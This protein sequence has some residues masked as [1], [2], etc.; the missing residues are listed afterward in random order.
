MSRSYLLGL[1][2]LA[3]AACAGV[4]G[5][6]VFKPTRY[7]HAVEVELAP[8]DF[9]QGSPGML[10]MGTSC[11]VL[12]EE[13]GL[14][15]LVRCGEMTGYVDKDELGPEKPTV[16]ALLQSAADPQAHPSDRLKHATRAVALAPAN[17]EALAALKK[18]YFDSQ[19]RTLQFNREED[20]PAIERESVCGESQRVEDC[21]TVELLSEELFTAMMVE[22]RGADFVAVGFRADQLYSVRGTLKRSPSAASSGIAYSVYAPAFGG[23]DVP[24]VSAA[25]GLKPAKELGVQPRYTTNGSY[26]SDELRDQLHVEDGAS[27]TQLV[28][29]RARVPAGRREGEIREDLHLM[30]KVELLLEG[31]FDQDGRNDA[32][33]EINT[34]GNCCEPCYFFATAP[35][36]GKPV[37]TNS[38]CSWWGPPLV[39][40][41][42]S[43]GGKA[44]FSL[45]E[46]NGEEKRYMLSGNKARRAP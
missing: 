28:N 41:M 7:I 15:A 30:M 38:F 1:I 13:E 34:G 44:T 36:K 45:P 20:Y 5:C 21:L 6:D 4:T 23:V 16:E 18:A 22:R 14:R 40:W 9:T 12:K 8:E 37:L 39:E 24:R 19:F 17:A 26:Y 2:V 31:D 35:R 43:G 42:A 25:L 46:K 10:P 27:S 33:V 29:L 32:L 11:K 3:A